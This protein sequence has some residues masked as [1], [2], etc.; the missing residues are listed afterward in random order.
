MTHLTPILSLVLA[1]DNVIYSGH[2]SVGTFCGPLLLPNEILQ[3]WEQDFYQP[4]KSLHP[5]ENHLK[6]I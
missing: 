4:P 1:A 2:T 5:S 3:K 6:C